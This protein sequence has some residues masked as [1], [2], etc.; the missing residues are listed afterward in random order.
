MKRSR[1]LDSHQH[2]WRIDRPEQRWPDADWPLIHRDFLPE[3]LRTAT[4]G[5]D[6]VGTVLVQSQPD[7][8]DTDWLLDLAAADPLILGVVGWVALDDAQAPTRIA[9]LAAREKCVGL[10]PMLQG[11]DDSNWILRDDLVPAIEAMLAHGLRFDALV[12]PR[13]LP[14]LARFAERWPDLPIVI[15]HGAKPYAAD[16][17][18]DPWRE[19]LAALARYPNIWCKL[20][21]LRTEQARGQSADALAPYVAHILSSFGERTMWGS[22]WPVLLHMGDCYTDWVDDALRLAGD[23]DALMHARL[24]EGAARAFYGLAATV[25]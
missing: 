19:Q 23:L 16:L 13:H 4:E 18:L 24:F 5:L 3:D 7:D 22:D 1:I 10:R 9:Q 17:I 2:F 15:D 20:S 14:V 12:Q 21:G 25:S 6:M 8:R 11:I